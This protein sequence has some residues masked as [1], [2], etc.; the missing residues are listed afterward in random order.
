L[1][2]NKLKEEY[3]SGD[4]EHLNILGYKLIGTSLAEFIREKQFF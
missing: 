3:D 1:D 2:K 4:G